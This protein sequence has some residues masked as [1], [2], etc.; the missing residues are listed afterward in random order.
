MRIRKRI[1]G[2][3]AVWGFVAALAVWFWLAGLQP[4]AE[5]RQLFNEIRQCLGT[6]RHKRPKGLSQEKWAFS[7]G[8]TQNALGNCCGARAYITDYEHFRR[9]VTELKRRVDGDVDLQTID[10]IWDEF[11][12]F[13]SPGAGYSERYRPTSRGRLKEAAT[14][15]L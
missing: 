7:V 9:F 2:P 11:V 12:A 15:G 13:S 10:W 14:G 1:V 4:A 6:M 5:H 3:L 8:Q